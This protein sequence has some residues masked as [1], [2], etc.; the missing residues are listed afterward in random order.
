MFVRACANV[1]V[2]T[3]VSLRK[4]EKIGCLLARREQMSRSRFLFGSSVF[5]GPALEVHS[6][7][8]NGEPP[9][10]NEGEGIIRSAVPREPS[11]DLKKRCGCFRFN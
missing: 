6:P 3:D 4:G 10:E 1:R 5:V 2:P 9:R 8:S 7:V 11:E